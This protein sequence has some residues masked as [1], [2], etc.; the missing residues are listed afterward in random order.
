[1]S[2]IEETLR[3]VDLMSN[4][5]RETIMKMITALMIVD[6]FGVHARPVLQGFQKYSIAECLLENPYWEPP[7]FASSFDRSVR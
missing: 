4:D 7:A 5:E 2:M 1:M 3:I 6:K